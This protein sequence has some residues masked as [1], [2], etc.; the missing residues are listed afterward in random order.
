MTEFFNVLRGCSFSPNTWE[1]YCSEGEANVNVMGLLTVCLSEALSAPHLSD[2]TP[3]AALPGTL[4]RQRTPSHI[5][6]DFGKTADKEQR[7]YRGYLKRRLLPAMTE[8]YDE[9]FRSV[10]DIDA[11]ESLTTDDVK[12]RLAKLT[13]RQL[14]RRLARFYEDLLDVRIPD[15]LQASLLRI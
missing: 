6:A 5:Q 3:M 11:V 7:S 10:G 1:S 15:L 12:Q 4:A 14:E 9:G 13:T 8:H 2:Q